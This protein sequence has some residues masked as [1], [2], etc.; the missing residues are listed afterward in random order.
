MP[1]N[2]KQ[3]IL[4]GGSIDRQ[5]ALYLIEEADLN[6]LCSAAHAITR[7]CAGTAFDTCS[8][9]NAKSGACSED[10]K[11]CAQSL[12]ARCE[13]QS[14][15]LRGPA[16]CLKRARYCA[17]QGV[18]R[19]AL[20]TSGRRP[21]SAEA[22]QLCA[23]YSA[24]QAG[25]PAISLC[26]SLGTC[27]AAQ[28]RSL[29]DAGVRRYHCNLETSPGFFAKVCTTHTQEQKITTLL[30]AREAGLELCSGGIIGMG[31]SHADR[32]DLALTLRELQVRS[33]PINVLHPIAGTALGSR[34]PLA[35]AEI[36]RTLAVFRF[37]LPDAALRLAGGRRLMSESLLR[38]ALEVGFN[39]AIVGDLL[40][41]AGSE[42]AADQARIQ[43][44]GYSS[45]LQAAPAA[46]DIFRAAPLNDGPTRV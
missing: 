21:S 5:E 26:A 25:C 6:E 42:L 37:I 23:I 30:H 20:V 24:L 35:E 9:L 18:Q 31:E 29:R 40:T 2:L 46:E 8:I 27:S 15:A 22:T 39:A 7:H 43:T 11:W 33:V 3:R 41:T 44:A 32:V 1:E 38:R 13:I 36:L 4:S 34:P 10:C 16:E 19:F 45:T 14:Y 17:S 12:H 28:L